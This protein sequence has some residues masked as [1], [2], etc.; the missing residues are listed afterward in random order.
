MIPDKI[1]IDIDT[2]GFIHGYN[3]EA[4]PP[5][6]QEYIRKEAL[7]EWLRKTEDEALNE[8]PM[9]DVLTLQKV[10]DKLNEM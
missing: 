8:V 10:I 3:A 9:L 5:A 7:L 1:Y 6:C 4:H 2:F